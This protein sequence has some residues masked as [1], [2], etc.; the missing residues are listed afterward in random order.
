MLHAVEAAKE[1]F[2]S[3]GVAID[4]AGAF[5]HVDEFFAY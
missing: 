2:D 1:S 3:P 4:F 5:A